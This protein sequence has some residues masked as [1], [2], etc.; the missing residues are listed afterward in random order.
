MS[1]AA[2]GPLLTRLA[3]SRAARTLLLLLGVAY[4]VAIPFPLLS[5]GVYVDENALMVAQV[6]RCLF[7]P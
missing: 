7:S 2:L 3:Q 5:Q 1:A 4:I 6:A